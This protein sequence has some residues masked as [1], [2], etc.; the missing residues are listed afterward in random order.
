[1]IHKRHIGGSMI[2]KTRQHDRQEAY[3]RQHDTHDTPTHRKAQTHAGVEE[4]GRQERS[5]KDMCKEREG[6]ELQPDT[7]NKKVYD[8][9]CHLGRSRIQ[10][11]KCAEVL[12]H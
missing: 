9:A 11:E 12:R 3:R 6:R 4:V 2:H 7:I 5:S 8:I 1:M 10:T